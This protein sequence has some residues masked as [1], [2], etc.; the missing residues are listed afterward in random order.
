MKIRLIE[1]ISPSRHLWSKSYFVRLGLPMIGAS[2]VQAGHDVRIFNPQLAPIDWADVYSSD[3]VGLS[4]TTSTAPEAYRISDDLRR[5]GIPVVIGG[6]HVTFMVDEALRH[7]DYVARGEGGEMIMVELAEL[8]EGKRDVGSISGISYL[9]DEGK[10]VHAPLHD[11]CPDLDLLPFPDLTLI[12][13]WQRITNTPIMTSWGC[14]FDC[15]FC[16]VT[17]MFGKKYRFRSAE[18]VIEEIKQKDP[19]RI[20]FYDDN[21]AANRKRLK[22]LLR[23]MIDE[24]IKVQWGAQ[25]RTDVVRDPELL[26][27]MRDSGCGFVA[28]GLE[29][30]NQATLDSFEKS[31]T[32]G[33]IEHAIKVLHEY[34][35]RSH[36][37]FV[38]GADHDTPGS[39][40]ET[41]EFAIRNKID[42]V[43][44]NIL[45]PL[46]GTQ[47]FQELEDEGRII[48]RDWSFYDAQHVVFR[49]RQM[50][51]LHLLQET[52]KANKRFY[53]TWRPVWAFHKWLWTSRKRAAERKAYV[54]DRM[55]EYGWLWYY[56]RTWWTAAKNRAQRRRLRALSKG[57]PHM[58]PAA[59]HSAVT[60]VCTTAAEAGCAD[61][62]G[63]DTRI[64]YPEEQRV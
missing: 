59:G 37:M 53:A 50:T 45:T 39:V 54:W 14:P 27:L 44:L 26:E 49:P 1:P 46:P 4:S 28:L 63:A 15:T 41:V 13:G 42:T 52:I 33:D 25:V 17:A 5:R 64:G 22:R 57:Q 12:D 56:S 62:H 10:P 23:M 30:V 58:M 61:A 38:L 36:G 47:Q 40:R 16:S 18:S 35:I 7:A 20:F 9:G 6:S 60:E 32:V 29:S 21:M 8:L 11:R 55:L 51:P 34:G 24:G 19:E 2:L 31:Q 3:L 48:E 43:M